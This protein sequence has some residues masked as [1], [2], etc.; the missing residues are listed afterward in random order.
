MET[1][2]NDVTGVFFYEQTVESLVECVKKFETM[3][4]N[5][6]KIRENAMRFGYKSFVNNFLDFF[7]KVVKCNF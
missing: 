2:V 4:F 5:H 1:V 7:K 3:S 6:Q